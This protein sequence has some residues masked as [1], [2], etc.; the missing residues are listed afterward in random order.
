MSDLKRDETDAALDRVCAALTLGL[1]DPGDVLDVAA[2]AWQ[3]VAMCAE[4]G[5]DKA[6][7]LQMV[8]DIYDARQH[9]EGN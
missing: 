1:I 6:A 9:V 3:G 8:E 2:V 5:L 4:V 7:M